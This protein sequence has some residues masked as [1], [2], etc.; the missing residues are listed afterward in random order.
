MKRISLALCFLLSL[1]VGL[2]GCMNDDNQDEQKIIENEADIEAYIKADSLGS[3]AVRDSSGLHFIT[4]KANPNGERVKLGDAATVKLNGYLFNGTKVLSIEKDSSLSF[5]AGGNATGLAGLELSVFL[6]KTGEKTT[7]LLPF[8]LAFGQIERVNVPA[9][10]P[11]RLEVELLKTRTEPQQ[12]DDFIKA[13]Q[14]T[15]SE[16]SSDNLVIVRTNTVTGDTIGVGKSVS[17]KYVGK[18]LTDKK[19]GEGTLSFITGTSGSGSAILGV[20]RAVRRMRKSE[21]AIIVFPSALGYKNLGT[22]DGT[23]PPYT[24]LQFEIEVQ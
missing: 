2:S 17:V 14:F 21:K 5:P 13:K 15:V 6:M 3:K 19:F 9:Y 24:T 4:R 1:A 7:F 18:F 12:I 8:Y 10:S 22:S 11:I 20:D 16:R 23:I